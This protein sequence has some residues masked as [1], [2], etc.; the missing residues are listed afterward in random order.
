MLHGAVTTEMEAREAAGC[1]VRQG[2]C[3][4]RVVGCLVVR[5]E[6][7]IYLQPQI[8]QLRAL[9]EPGRNN[10]HRGVE[11]VDVQAHAN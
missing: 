8:L 10:L 7:C 4:G 2:N 5:K 9:G 6:F 11:D 3:G 1:R